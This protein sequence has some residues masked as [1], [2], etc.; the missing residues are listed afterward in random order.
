[1][2]TLAV[3]AALALTQGPAR[4]ETLDGCR[5]KWP[6]ADA[7]LSLV[8]A[9]REAPGE[10]LIEGGRC[11]A[12]A[13]AADPGRRRAPDLFFHRVAW[14]GDPAG[15]FVVSAE[16][17]PAGGALPGQPARSRDV[18][19]IDLIARRDGPAVELSYSAEFSGR[20][21]LT[22]LVVGSGID[23][24]NPARLRASL[25]GM[26]VF[27]AALDFRSDGRLGDQLDR[28]FGPRDRVSARDR[29]RAEAMIDALPAPTI[30]DASRDAAR[31][32]IAAQ[33]DPRGRGR[34]DLIVPG[35]M[36][37]LRLAALLAG[38]MGDPDGTELPEG[39]TLD[40]TYGP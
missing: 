39:L 30:S 13:V 34:I 11:V 7:M 28:T 38:A 29:R 18:A 21:S 8:A 17:D 1:M 37:A 19:L 33:P 16:A 10:I 9:P 35:G 23:T 14:S 3:L 32:L 25:A 6:A 12:L 20:N 15:V 4:A 31:R 36:K 26:T 24:G 27:R 40:V 22:L 2:R 5:A